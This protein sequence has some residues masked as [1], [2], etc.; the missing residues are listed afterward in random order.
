MTENCNLF[1]KL[2]SCIFSIFMDRNVMKTGKIYATRWL[3]TSALCLFCCLLLVSVTVHVDFL[4][5]R[6]TVQQWI[7]QYFKLCKCQRKNEWTVSI[8]VLYREEIL[9]RLFLRSIWLYKN[10]W[11]ILYLTMYVHNIC[12]GLHFKL[13]KCQRKHEWYYS[14]VSAL[15][16]SLIQRR[17]FAH[18]NFAQT[19]FAVYSTKISPKIQSCNFFQG[20]QS[21]FV[22]NYCI[23]YKS[24]P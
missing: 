14:T 11:V 9:P 3:L 19:L 10:V 21:E 4:V 22:I 6:A 18:T 12:T 1:S 7:Y 13:C 8:L 23:Q 2:L 15:P 5:T 17:N 16:G 24:K 20:L